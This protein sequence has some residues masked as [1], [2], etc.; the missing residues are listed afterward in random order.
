MIK[1]ADILERLTTLME[2]EL[3]SENL[4]KALFC[5]E[6]DKKKI[7]R[8]QQ[9]KQSYVQFKI[10]KVEEQNTHY[11]DITV[12]GNPNIFTIELDEKGGKMLV[13]SEP[14]L[15]YSYL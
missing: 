13:H 2:K 14:K 7:K 5:E 15:K 3:T 12:M 6:K 10:R 9:G 8:F 11:G 4:H 1:K